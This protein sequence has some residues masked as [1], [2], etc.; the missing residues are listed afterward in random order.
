MRAP[1]THQ[2]NWTVRLV[3]L[4]SLS[5]LLCAP[6]ASAI[7]QILPAPPVSPAPVVNYEY[8][9]QGNPTKTIQAPNVAGFD[10]TTTHTY[11][12][13]NILKDSTNAKAGVTQFDYNG[14]DDLTQII[15][16]RNLTTQY[17]RNGLGDVTRLISPDTG[18]A[19]HTYDAAGNLKKRTD[20]RGVLATYTYDALNRLSKI[21]YSK[22]GSTS[23]TYNWTYDQ[24]GSGY[25]NGVGRLTSTVSPT[26]STRY[27]YDP[28]GRLLTD[29]QRVKLLTGAN[30][31][32]IS[33]TV[34][35]T[36]DAAGN[37]AS[38]LYPSGRQLS[39]TYTDGQP[40]AL[41]LAKN[42]TTPPVNLI[43]AIQWEPFGAPKSWLWQMASD[44]QLHERIH[45]SYGRIVRYPLGNNVR[46]I[47]YDAGDRITAYTH[48]DAS[49]LTATPSLDQSFGYDELG[50][51]TSVITATANW[52]IGYDAN[53]NRTSVTQN[54]STRAYTTETTSN[55]LASL[56]NPTRSLSYDNAGNTTNDSAGYTSTY[57]LAG[58]MATLTKEGIT[59]TYSVDGM[60]RRVRKFNSTGAISTL[61]FVYG[62]QGQ[63]LGEYS[64]T[65][66]ALREYVW[67]NNIPIAMFTPDPA[68]SAN[69][70][71]TYYFHTDHLGT[72]RVVIDKNNALRWRWLAEPFG[73][74]TP[75]NFGA[76]TQPLRFP[77]QYA[78]AESGLN[79]NYFRD[80]DPSTGRYTQS[81]PI[82]LG[83]GINTYTYVGGN[84]LSFV[85]PS[86]LYHCAPG[87]NCNFSPAMDSSLV[88]FDDCSGLDNEI[89]SGYREGGGP[90]GH[91]DGA[92]MNRKNNR[93]LTPEKAKQC[94]KKCFSVGYGQEEQNGPNSSDPNGTH[95]HFQ[96]YSKSG[97]NPG[98]GDGIR[99]YQPSPPK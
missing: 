56:T 17:L 22:S 49:T 40:S 91:G 13:L 88:C 86:G 70:P 82:G 42:T 35:Y 37:V 59:T 32:Q 95:F 6:L 81:D 24:V 64:N 18:T 30:S 19:T 55:R 94:R 10:I 3:R 12:T 93:C 51:L 73:T 4:A 52:S 92:D 87:A 50:R 74:T 89:T 26:S 77:G 76:F 67:L 72:P 9:A 69:P 8:D 84:P 98:W 33:K 29:I 34:T 1:Q 7:V 5:S 90:H 75:E 27:T 65:G 28:Q 78:D 48:Y 47:T 60:N 21:S 38:I 85:D 41:N 2:P 61:I 36:Y 15:D 11:D 97:T 23:L 96:E 63:L 83:G 25:V 99:P 45:D 57:D 43:S 44:T 53:G 79:Y 46:D 20:S 58:R 39:I 14:R 71:L 80:Y 68:R 62:Q 66:T 54:A 16:P 31:A